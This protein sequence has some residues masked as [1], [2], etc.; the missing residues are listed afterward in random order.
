MTKFKK[1]L[2]VILSAVGSL[3]VVA[4]AI[5]A[6][7]QT[8]KAMRLI[9][10]YAS[11]NDKKVEDLTFKEGAKVVWKSYIPTVVLG[12]GTIACIIGSSVLS[13]RQQAALIGAYSV[14][15][16]NGED[17]VRKV[18][19]HYGEE[20][21]KQILAELAAEQVD[22]EHVI[23]APS[24]FENSAIDVM[25][26]DEKPVMFYDAIGK[27]YFESTISKV[28]LAQYHLNRNF[29]LGMIPSLNEF[30]ELLGLDRTDYGET[31]G[32]TNANGDYYWIDFNLYSKIVKDGVPVYV[33]EP[34]FWPT[35]EYLE[36]L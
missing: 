6:V 10:Q 1:A 20:A 13:R 26:S 9:N 35:E 19:E 24:Y 27:R 23:Y 29:T 11:D 21:H 7:K 30:Y 4:T 15:R 3:G 5:S 22:P 34:V 12:A 18:K 14:L 16:K 31:V 8:P 2:P 33:I 17:Y 28:L 25:P 36:D 32:W